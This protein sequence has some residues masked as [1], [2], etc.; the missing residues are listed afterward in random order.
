MEGGNSENKTTENFVKNSEPIN[1]IEEINVNKVSI[2][3]LRSYFDK[4]KSFTIFNEP[5][6]NQ[7]NDIK[8]TR[9]FYDQFNNFKASSA[10]IRSL[11]ANQSTSNQFAKDMN[12]VEKKENAIKIIKLMKN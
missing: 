1:E 8:Q 5:T 11:M 12:E 10:M 9:P 6:N 7:S 2:E 3:N 4:F